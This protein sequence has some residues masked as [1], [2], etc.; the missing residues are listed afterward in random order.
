MPRVN[1]TLILS[2]AWRARGGRQDCLSLARE[3]HVLMQNMGKAQW[4]CLEFIIFFIFLERIKLSKSHGAVIAQEQVH[5]VTF[6]AILRKIKIS[7]SAFIY[8]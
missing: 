5:S 8:Q 6:I 1:K 7:Q 3:S 4:L 2:H